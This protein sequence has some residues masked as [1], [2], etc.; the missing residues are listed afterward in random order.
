MGQ[1]DIIDDFENSVY[2][3]ELVSVSDP[4]FILQIIINSLGIKEE[5]G[6]TLKFSVT[7]YLKDKRCLS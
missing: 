2:I 5:A 1:T 4:A 7:G 3:S 6:K